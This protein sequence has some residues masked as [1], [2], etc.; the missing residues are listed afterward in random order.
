MCVPFIGILQ[1]RWF[2]F[3]KSLIYE[4]TLGQ[5]NSTI[6]G[7]DESAVISTYY[8]RLKTFDAKNNF[9]E[10]SGPLSASYIDASLYVSIDAVVW[11]KSTG[12]TKQVSDAE[13]TL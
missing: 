12:L 13:N 10:W 6:F 11:K 9:A 3:F 7:L 5:I 8:F 1:A 4:S 2:T